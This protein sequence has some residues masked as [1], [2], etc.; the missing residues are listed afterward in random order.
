MVDEQNLGSI[1]ILRW[2]GPK[3]KAGMWSAKTG[4]LVLT[5]RRLLFLSTGKSGVTVP[6]LLTG[7]ISGEVDLSKKG[8]LEIP[9]RNVISASL[10]TKWVLL[11]VRY[12]D[13]AD[14]EQATTFGQQVD[15]MPDGHAWQTAI[16]SAKAAAEA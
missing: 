14:T 2:D 5:S 13:V 8:S 3:R 12:R 4:Q 15:G 1:S 9:L 11:V 6:G 7:V 10:E 16:I